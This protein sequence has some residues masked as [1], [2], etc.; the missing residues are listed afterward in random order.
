MPIARVLT[1]WVETQ[2]ARG[3]FRI[4]KVAQDYP[5][6]YE[7]ATSQE[8]EKL[9]VIDG[10]VVIRLMASEKTLAQIESDERYFVLDSSS[11]DG[12]R[13]VGAVEYDKLLTWMQTH[14]KQTK[15]ETKEWLGQD[16]KGRK[17]DEL[18]TDIVDY[19]KSSD[20]IEAIK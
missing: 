14:V 10:M 17:G 19:I 15:E 7:D 20:V 2:E 3:V 5:V 4:P 16:P 1:P 11:K 12:D 6:G 8:V 13:L 18:I 9:S